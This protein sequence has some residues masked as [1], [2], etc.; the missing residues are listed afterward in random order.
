MAVGLD[1]WQQAALPRVT[2]RM[3]GEETFGP[4]LPPIVLSLD[5]GEDGEGEE[6]EE[7]EEEGGEFWEYDSEYGREYEMG[8][9]MMYGTQYGQEC[10]DEEFVTS[11]NHVT[12]ICDELNS[13]SYSGFEDEYP[14]SSPVHLAQISIHEKRLSHQ[15]STVQDVTDEE[16]AQLQ[17]GETVYNK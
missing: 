6:G 11:Q 12:Q 16:A 15:K 9:G 13:P 8:Y 1:S 17:L 2:R 5:D 4:W 3:S 10:S 14:L 7:G